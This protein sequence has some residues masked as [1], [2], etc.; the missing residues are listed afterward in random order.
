MGRRLA[1][2]V[3]ALS[4]DELSGGRVDANRIYTLLCD[5]E[6]GGC[7]PASPA[8]LLDCTSRGDFLDAMISLIQ[9][10][11]HQDQLI[12]YFSGHGCLKNNKYTL[13]FG[14]KP[15]ETYLPFDSITADLQAHGVSRSI[16]ILDACHS[17]AA[18]KAGQKGAADLEPS[19]LP[20]LP[21]GIAVLA[22]CRESESSYE[23]DGGSGSVF[24]HLL[25]L[26]IRSGLGGKTTED[27]FIGPGDIIEFVNT[28]LREKEF[29]D[30]P[31]K[32]A[33]C[34]YAAD[35]QVWLAR[36]RTQPDEQVADTPPGA[37]R[38]L[39]EL[40]LLYEKME[41]SRWPCPSASIS[42]LDPELV[43][44]YAH[45]NRIDERGSGIE[46]LAHT[47][48]LYSSLADA[49]LHTA[50]VLC[51]AESP[52]LHVPQARSMFTVGKR[53]T[54]VFRRDDVLGPL[55][56][57]V[58]QLVERVK[59]EIDRQH[60]QTNYNETQLLFFQVIREAISNAITHRDYQI[61]G[62]VRVSLNFPQ[63]EIFSPG[64]FAKG[65][66]FESLLNAEHVSLPTDA[67]VALYLTS[68]LAFE[69]VGRG[70]AVF[71]DFVRRTDDKHLECA[72]TDG[73][74]F[75]KI[76]ATFPTMVTS[77]TGDV[78]VS[79]LEDNGLLPPFED[80]GPATMISRHPAAEPPETLPVGQPEGT[81]SIPFERID[82]Y[83]IDAVIGRGATGPVY[84]AED[85]RLK[86]F[87]VIKVLSMRFDSQEFQSRFQLEAR[88]SARLNH[89]NIVSLYDIGRIEDL[90]Y[91]VIE[92]IEGTSLHRFIA[93]SAPG[94]GEEEEEY[95]V[96][97]ARVCAQV[98]S[99][100]AHAH[101]HDVIHRDIK[102]SNILLDKD[103]NAH[104]SD[105]GIS[106][107]TDLNGEMLTA[108]GSIVGTPEY[109][110][111]EQAQSEDVD[112][113]A[114]I[115]S[116]G[117]VL[118]Q[119]L[120]HE[121]PYVAG[122]ILEILIAKGQRPPRPPRMINTRIPAVLDEICLRAVQPKPDDRYSTAQQ[123]ADELFDFAGRKPREKGFLSRWLRRS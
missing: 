86:R 21:Q 56:R 80:P 30:Y 5:E 57:Q 29:A 93:E 107:D 81:D 8:L 41:K 121:L 44:A 43:R 47:L 40:R 95:F 19:V 123:M 17:G 11:D 49:S 111:P 116:L 55:S 101:E 77:T 92:Y 34:V 90:S 98:A 119:L 118:Y 51:F 3:H 24:T 102:P 1:L 18:L 70:F 45:A 76:T 72:E 25:N 16:I 37:S 106:K 12:L 96:W 13:V 105:F 87:V 75:V 114:D 15:N 48:K 66:T 27:G 108:I 32:P 104:V 122:N 58:T 117:V 65:Q 84:L 82:H 110:A 33:F 2:V 39:E 36:N 120:S 71:E 103:G 28:K 38:T 60:R 63:V 26:G 9:N 88:I 20:D 89:P 64:S 94:R 6:L 69:G 83:R 100:L 31:Q 14:D 7:D 79:L 10:W 23:L 68:L 85:E 35:R 73:D 99:A 52:H 53:T 78:K 46:G 42:D 109:M 59:Q 50:A 97:V 22:S 54:K 113:R 74:S 4:G 115:Y 62:V 61:N 67:A 91:F 112:K